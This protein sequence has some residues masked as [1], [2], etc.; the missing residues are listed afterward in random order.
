MK[1]SFFNPILIRKALLRAPWFPLNPPKKPLRKPPKGISFFANFSLEKCGMRSNAAN[2][3][4]N[5]DIIK[6]VV[7]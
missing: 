6:V 4:N 5:N 3:I 2:A 1:T 7:V